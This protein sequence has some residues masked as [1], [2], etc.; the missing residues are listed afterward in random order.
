M[1]ELS[2]FNKKLQKAMGVKKSQ[3]PKMSVNKLGEFL[4]ATPK[5]QRSILKSL[6]YPGE[7]KFRFTGY[8]D[9]RK[10]IKEYI[11]GNFDEEILLEYIEKLEIIPDEEKDNFTDSSILALTTV[12]ESNKLPD[13]GFTF[14]PYEGMNPK[15]E[16][17]GVEV[18]VYPDFVVHSETVKGEY[19]GAAKI[20]ISKAGH[21]G[22][23]GGKYISTMIYDFTG[24]Y[25]DKSGRT[26]RNTNCISYDVFSDSLIECPKSI[27]RRWVEIEAG[28]KNIVAI[29]DSI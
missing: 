6:K 7:N 18:S 2:D 29:W 23:E 10:A 3:P 17:E 19:C 16:I 5:R 1:E 14:L 15:L 4:V 21:F 8:N 12:L 28:C 11:L 27:S 25:I 13:S 22:E 26:L 24:K 9:A 20:H